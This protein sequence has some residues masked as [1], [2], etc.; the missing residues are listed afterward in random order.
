MKEFSIDNWIIGGTI[1]LI[2]LTLG[3][4]FYFQHELSVLDNDYTNI[5]TPET[6]NPERGQV[7]SSEQVPGK[8]IQ[9]DETDN[10]S[11]N[12]SVINRNIS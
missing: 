1:F 6:E 11:S 3:C 2:V 9:S 12:I 4:Y 8:T 7:E 10:D 5:E